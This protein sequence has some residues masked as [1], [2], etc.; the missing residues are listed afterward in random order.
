MDF[1]E[2]SAKTVDDAITKA[3]IELGLSSD[4]LE[5]QVISEGSSG[6]LGIGSKPAVIQVRRKKEKGS[7]HKSE[8]TLTDNASEKKA[9]TVKAEKIKNQEVRTSVQRKVSEEASADNRK[10]EKKTSSEEISGVKKSEK[11]SERENKPESKASEKKEVPVE[12]TAEEIVT[13]KASASK[14]LDGI[15]KAMELPV[16]ITIEYNQEEGS[17][18][19]DF[20]G[21]DMGILIGKRGQTL[22]SLQYLVS[23]VVNKDQKNYVRVKLDTEDYRRRRKETLEN[24][25]NNIA[26]KVRRRHHAVSLEAMNQYERRII[27]SALQN[28]KYVET[29]SEGN[30][31]Y[32]HVVVTLKKSG[33]RD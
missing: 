11:K 10:E 31:P 16:N 3:C 14:F 1:L 21:D 30:E 9:E 25:A 4:Q 23:L 19:I 28:N 22:D 6:F 15:F 24:L 33:Y 20:E 18:D 8:N 27:H 2:V 13:M 5:I 29:H 26:N 32:R 7:D 17:L 12:R